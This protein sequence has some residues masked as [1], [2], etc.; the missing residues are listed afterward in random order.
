MSEIG[1]GYS[2]FKFDING[3]LTSPDILAMRRDEE[4]MYIRIIATQGRDGMLMADPKALAAQAMLDIRGLRKWLRGWG[5]LVP[6]I[7][8]VPTAEVATM[9]QSCKEHAPHGQQSCSKCVTKW[10]QV[11]YIPAANWMQTGSKR[12]NPKLWNL[13]VESGKFAG[14][15]FLEE[16]RGEGILDTNTDKTY[17]R[18][19]LNLNSN[20]KGSG[21]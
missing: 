7:E 1:N 17:T 14:Q 19:T 20:A 9:Q 15:P 12:A 8:L 6:I 11:C 4:G 3:W 13:S 16:N 2:W 5:H 10:Q 18:L 21:A